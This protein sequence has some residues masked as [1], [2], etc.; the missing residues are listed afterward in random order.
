MSSLQA[1]YSGAFSSEGLT[2]T[3]AQVLTDGNIANKA[4]NMNSNDITAV[5]DITCSDLTSTSDIVA[6]NMTASGIVSLRQPLNPSYNTLSYPITAG[7][8]GSSTSVNNISEVFAN[9]LP[10]NGLYTTLFVSSTVLPLGVYHISCFVAGT[11]TVSEP[12]MAMGIANTLDTNP[13]L[14]TQGSVFTKS[15]ENGFYFNF[16]TVF[17][18]STGSQSPIF[19][20]SSVNADNSLTALQWT[21]FKIG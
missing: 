18:S 21:A 19:K 3:L 16:A 13:P 7:A 10:V 9:P 1:F 11:N 15:A 6:N 5:R 20:Y 17:V 12:N 4:I 2:T 8:V 14:G